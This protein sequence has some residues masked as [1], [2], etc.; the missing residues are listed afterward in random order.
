MSA[1]SPKTTAK[2]RPMFVAHVYVDVDWEDQHRTPDFAPD[3]HLIFLFGLLDEGLV[4]VLVD[5]DGAFIVSVQSE[6][7][8]VHGSVEA[9]IHVDVD[10]AITMGPTNLPPSPIKAAFVWSLGGAW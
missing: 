1:S 6:N 8:G 5:D 10:G 2:F 4:D 3:H 9:H 7:A